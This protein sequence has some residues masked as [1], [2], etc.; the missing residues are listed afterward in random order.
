MDNESIALL[1]MLILTASRQPAERFI[2][3][4]RLSTVDLPGVR[5]IFKKSVEKETEKKNRRFL[6]KELG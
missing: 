5:K 4:Q 6:A 3:Y 2:G 1:Q